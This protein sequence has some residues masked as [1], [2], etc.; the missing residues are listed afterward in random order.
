MAEITAQ[1]LYDW[2]ISSN[3]FP[4]KANYQEGSVDPS[5]APSTGKLTFYY[6]TTSKKVFTYDFS[7]SSWKEGLGG[8]GGGFSDTVSIT[9]NTNITLEPSKAYDLV[10]DFGNAIFTLPTPTSIGQTVRVYNSTGTASDG[11]YVKL[12]GDTNITLNGTTDNYIFNLPNG[13]VDLISSSL[14]NWMIL[15]M[16]T[17][18]TLPV[19]NAISI[20]SNA[21][22]VSNGITYLVDSSTSVTTVTVPT[23]SSYPFSF[24]IADTKKN[25]YAKNITI[26]FTTNGNKFEGNADNFVINTSGGVYQFVATNSIYGF[27]ALQENTIDISNLKSADVTTIN[28]QNQ[29]T[30]NTLV[31]AS[32]KNTNS[33]LMKGSDGNVTLNDCAWQSYTPTL[34]SYSGTA[35]TMGSGG[36]VSALYRVVGKTLQI[37]YTSNQTNAGTAGTGHYTVSI[38]SGFSINTTLV[39]IP[40]DLATTQGS[41]TRVASP[42]LGSGMAYV[43][44]TAVGIVLA[45]PT[46]STTLA[47]TATSGN[48]QQWIGS[49]FYALS[50]GNRQFSFMAEIPIV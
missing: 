37:K 21:F 8:G 25:A 22:T 1:G 18:P 7:T 11:N 42:P 27:T 31:N 35:P 16:Y 29:S 39:T 38:P 41:N 10:S 44:S 45:Y 3:G 48:S 30:L 46:S 9:T 43:N 34:G 14:T 33:I 5:T 6:N 4:S 26:D 13:V 20:S 50:N 36:T 32:A 12:K 28:N 17:M 15:P 49:S 47:F 19:R 2:L 24:V 23:I 40:A